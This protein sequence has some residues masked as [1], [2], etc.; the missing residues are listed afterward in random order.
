MKKVCLKLLLLLAV[1]FL[2][3]TAEAKN[4]NLLIVPFDVSDGGQ[5]SDMRDSIQTMLISRLASHAGVNVLDNGMSAVQLEQLGSGKQFKGLNK[6]NT[7]VYLVTGSLFQI[8]KEVKVQV[9]LIPII[10]GGLD[11]NAPPLSFSAQSGRNDSLIS[12]MAELARK[13]N[14]GAFEEQRS[15]MGEGE[16]NGMGA[17]VTRHPEKAWKRGQ[18]SSLAAITGSKGFSAK[19][20]GARSRF[21]FEDKLL[22]L[23]VVDADGDGISD[24]FL[25]FSYRIEVQQLVDHRLR[26][27]DA[28][29]LPSG[30]RV[31]AWN[32]ADLNRDGMQSLYL[33]A[34]RGL[35]PDSGVLS[36]SKQKGFAWKKKN[37]PFYIRPVLL[38]GRGMTLLVQRRGLAKIALRRP[39]VFISSFDSKGDVKMEQR[40]SLPKS[41]NLFDFEYAD[42]DGDNTAELVVIGR[43]NHLKV[44]SGANELLFVSEKLYGGSRL[45]IGPTQGEATAKQSRSSF[46]I[47]EDA[48]RELL[49]MPGRILVVDFN[50][51]GHKEIVVAQ[52]SMPSL[53]FLTRLRLFNSGTITGLTWNGESFIP[54]WE[55][56]SFRGYLSDFGMTLRKGKGKTQIGT[57]YVSNLPSSGTLL[58]LLP[59]TKESTLT[60]GRID[61]STEAES[62][63]K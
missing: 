49:Y 10:N 11:H 31:H 35:K 52:S 61:F 26:P 56:G 21:D 25:F 14:A 38:P 63:E 13:I 41:V 1:F 20:V 15:V 29:S 3:L 9:N 40:L 18:Y 24:I 57:L 22:G 36:W 42:L 45:Y 62:E 37:I 17:F 30:L 43:H 39:G 4:I 6:K 19:N 8:K 7:D 27:V 28:C 34:T 23:Q 5:Y 33:S 51:D 2:P 50:G 47:E 58:S 46:S 12:D 59:G 16:K 32:F 60:V 44:F 48:D 53:G 54:F 55:T